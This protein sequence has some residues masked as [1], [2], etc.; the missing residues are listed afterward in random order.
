[1]KQSI[2]RINWKSLGSCDLIPQLSRGQYYAAK[3]LAKFGSFEPPNGGNDKRCMRA[4]CMV[5]EGCAYYYAM[6]GDELTLKGMKKAV[7][8]FRKYRH[9]ARARRIPYPEAGEGANIEYEMIAIHV[10]RNMRG[11]RAVAHILED[12][13]LLREVAEELIGVPID[14]Y[15]WEERKEYYEVSIRKIKK[16]H[17][18]QST[19]AYLES[20]I[21]NEPYRKNQDLK[22]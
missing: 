19:R 13:K 8:N 15:E 3:S 10:G 20:Y 2:R 18:I 7:E 1:M 11:M 17:Q 14:S 16:I 21:K 9:V 4:I 5:A 6:T 12:E 22:M